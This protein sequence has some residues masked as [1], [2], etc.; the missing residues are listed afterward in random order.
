MA[1][2]QHEHDNDENGA[3]E[4]IVAD[5]V[6]GAIDQFRPIVER[7]ELDIFRQRLL[8]LVDA[9]PHSLDNGAGVLAEQH[10]GNA[11]HDLAVALSRHGPLTQRGACYD[12]S[13]IAHVHR[14][15]A[16]PGLHD[17]ARQIVGGLREA[18]TADRVL[19]RSVRDVAT[20]DIRVVSRDG[21]VHVAQ[22]QPVRLQPGGVNPHLILLF[23]PPEAIH[24]RDAGDAEQLAPHV[25]VLQRPKRL[26]VECA[27]RGAAKLILVNLAQSA[28][29]RPHF[30]DPDRRGN[31]IARL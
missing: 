7:H 1:E 27:A 24:F 10:D 12:L 3:F 31:L 4:E 22:V 14:Y 11:G 29:N 23:E 16:R 8:D 21:L 2:Q 19:L 25:P 17:D 30:R 20:A 9:L 5:G 13:E 28:G 26:H 15:T 6:D 18:D